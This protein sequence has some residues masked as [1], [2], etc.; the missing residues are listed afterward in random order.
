MLDKEGRLSRN[1][2]PDLLHPNAKGY[3]SWAETIDPPGA[4]AHGRGVCRH[5]AGPRSERLVAGTPQSNQPADQARQCRSAD[6][7]RL[8]HRRLG[9]RGKEVWQKFY[10]KRNAV[11]LGIGGD[12]TQQVLWRLENGNIDGIQPKLAVVMIGTNNV[13][14]R[15]PQEIAAGVR[16]VVEKLRAKLPKTKVL[17]LAIFP[18]GA[19]TQDRS[20]VNSKVNPLIA[21]LADDKDVFFL[22][23]GPKF[24]DQDGTLPKDIMP[25]FLH[26]NAK[27]YE[28]W[29]E[30]M[31]P[32]VKKLMGEE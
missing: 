29:A 27:G 4:D 32:M 1:I 13:G 11:N 19:N 8:D 10:A 30:A 23:I 14:C 21:K 3:A 6:D 26:P 2:M 5:Q 18:R 24:F 17:L 28:M 22:D 12:Q 31:E 7:R 25:D 15:N 16:A 20:P 9:G